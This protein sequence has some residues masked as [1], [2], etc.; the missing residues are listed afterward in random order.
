MAQSNKIALFWHGGTMRNIDYVCIA[1]M[2]YC[3]MDVTL[4]HFDPIQNVPKGTKF[5]DASI[6]LDRKFIG[7]LKG[8][9]RPADNNWRAVLQ[10]SDLFRIEIQRLGLGMWFDPDILLFKPFEYETSQTW[11]ADEGGGRIGSSTYYLPPNH[12]II[13]EYTELLKTDDLKPNWLSFR[14][15]SLR[16][17]IWRLTGRKFNTSDLGITI[18][19]NDAFNRLAKRYNCY[20]ERHPKDTFYH[21]I[22]RETNH[23][24]DLKKPHD[25]ELDP[26]FYGIHVHRKHWENEVIK[27][28]SLWEW[29]VNKY[30]PDKHQA[31]KWE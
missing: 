20:D 31:F 14:R 1:S 17:L 25:F 21:W 13:T 10:F 4:Y 27:R 16:P 11:F 18:Y 29:A 15:G 22:A 7:R 30:A 2:L 24:F 26:R 9:R 5:G 6:V 8:L 12:P 19:G 28:G 23:I 3:G